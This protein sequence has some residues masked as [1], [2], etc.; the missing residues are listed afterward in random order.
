MVTDRWVIY[1]DDDTK[2]IVLNP[3]MLL[4]EEFDLNDYVKLEGKYIPKDCTVIN[5]E[6]GELEI[7]FVKLTG[8]V[9]D[10]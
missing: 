3:E 6:T 1:E 5:K 9:C 2:E 8:E 7:D 10:G 4:D